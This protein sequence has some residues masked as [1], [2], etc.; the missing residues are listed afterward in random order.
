MSETP[1]PDPTDAAPFRWLSELAWIAPIALIALCVRMPIV[2][3][4]VEVTHGDTAIVYMMMSRI[5]RGVELPLLYYGQ[6]YMGAIDPLMAA[7]LYWLTGPSYHTLALAQALIFSLLAVPLVYRLLW[8]IGGRAPARLGTL[9]TAIGSPWLMICTAGR[10]TGYLSNFW[11]GTLVL[12]LGMRLLR[13]PCRRDLILVG[14][15]VGLGWYNNPQ[16]ALFFGPLAIAFWLAHG[17][18]PK[19]RA[20]GRLLRGLGGLR[21]ILLAGAL[22]LVLALIVFCAWLCLEQVRV[23]DAEREANRVARKT[24][25]PMAQIERYREQWYGPVLVSAGES[26][27]TYVRFGGTKDTK[28]GADE[29][30]GLTIKL[31]APHGYIPK[32]II[33]V[34]LL[35]ALIELQLAVDRRLLLGGALA[36]GLAAGIG[37]SP[38]V[39]AELQGLEGRSA[40]MHI[41][42][43]WI[44]ER[45]K[46]LRYMRMVW[47][48]DVWEEADTAPPAWFWRGPWSGSP[49][50]SPRQRALRGSHVM[51]RAA[52]IAIWFTLL[53]A[54]VWARRGPLLDL[55]LLRRVRLGLLEILLLQQT[56]VL[57]LFMQHPLWAAGR[58]F[59]YGW[60]LLGG[61]VG[62]AAVAL[63]RAG[64]W[65]RWL[66]EAGLLILL[67]HYGLVYGMS[68]ARIYDGRRAQEEQLLAVLKARGLENMV[69]DY[70]IGYHLLYLSEERLLIVSKRAWEERLRE[71]RI[72]LGEKRDVR[73]VRLV[74]DWLHGD[75]HGIDGSSLR[76]FL[77]RPFNEPVRERWRHG[78]HLGYV[79]DKRYTN[80]DHLPHDAREDQLDPPR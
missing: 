8:E 69:A 37:Y 6:K 3:Q 18:I 76:D 22:L 53:G 26:K 25:Q 16:M 33:L 55:L 79:Y 58:Y 75:I 38:K 77:R 73:L 51:L 52:T 45:V 65:R 20:E 50:L 17:S 49:S 42:P 19:L 28:L 32:L 11:L 68:V 54:F 31:S 9:V 47:F 72:A 15:L 30:S 57:V 24:G 61:L 41:N 13:A 74:V 21:A 64:G 66:A 78:P 1:E 2:E 23:R 59:I 12:V 29:P 80:F 14:L 10:Y 60:I 40:P 71:K 35:V 7:P 48:G 43:G 34:A 63:W 62:W 44:P 67:L 36:F 39:V 4:A 5:A 46:E 56:M 70:N 27:R